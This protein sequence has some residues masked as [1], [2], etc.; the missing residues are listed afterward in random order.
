MKKSFIVICIIQLVLL[1][2]CT[3]A[4]EENKIIYASDYI[5]V[6]ELRENI[7]V[8]DLKSDEEYHFTKV[9]QAKE[10]TQSRFEYKTSIETDTLQIKT[11]KHLIIN[12]KE[13]GVTV[14]I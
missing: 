11:G 1:T 12:I 10:T 9:R 8:Y 13:T 6:S 5:T 7:K 4:V 14:V 3:T 2:G